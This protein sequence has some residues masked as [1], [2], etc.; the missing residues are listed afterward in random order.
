MN[1]KPQFNFKTTLFK[2]IK[3]AHAVVIEG[4]EIE[5]FADAPD[6]VQRLGTGD[7]END[8]YF[9]DQ[10][11]E[12][13]DEGNC[14]AETWEEQDEAL[15][16]GEDDSVKVTLQFSVSRPLSAADIGE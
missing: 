5:E 14:T 10:D 3:A 16:P 15:L 1:A 7:G 13:D 12:I 9:K 4:Y 8:W 2:A 6:E 11:V